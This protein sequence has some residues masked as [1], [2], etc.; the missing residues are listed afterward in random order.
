M[1]PRLNDWVKAF[2]PSLIS[3]LESAEAATED[4][5]W[6]LALT[7]QRG[8]KLTRITWAEM[9]TLTKGDPTVARARAFAATVTDLKVI[10]IA[11]EGQRV[12]ASLLSLASEAKG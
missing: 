3:Y 6:V 10:V 2:L 5:P 9:D 8:I 11:R 1:T 7:E 4:C 12:C